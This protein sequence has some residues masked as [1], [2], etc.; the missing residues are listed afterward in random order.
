MNKELSKLEL[1][2]GTA[3]YISG[4]NKAD[5]VEDLMPCVE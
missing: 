1:M 5:L 2:P 4:T 3:A